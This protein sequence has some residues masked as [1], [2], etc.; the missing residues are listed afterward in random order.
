MTVYT[1]YASP[2]GVLTLCS[3]AEALTG[4][5]LEQNC[6]NLDT[7]TR[8]EDL[9]VFARVKDWLDGYF[10]GVPGEPDFRVEPAG[11][12]FQKQVWEIL[13]TVPWGRTITYGNIG[14]KIAP[15]MSARAV[16]QAVGKNPISILIPCHRCL[17]AGGKLTGYAGGLENKKWLL[18]HEGISFEK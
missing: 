1:Q 18:A 8:K 14:E 6:P 16:G 13:L 7:M 3:D 15:G 17:G 2:V 10:A 5:W 4:L 9:P 11:T 12:K